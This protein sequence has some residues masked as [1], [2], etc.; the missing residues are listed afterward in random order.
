[1]T[2]IFGPQKGIPEKEEGVFL[3][4]FLFFG[5]LVDVFWA[6]FLRLLVNWSVSPSVSWVGSPSVS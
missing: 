5:C 1:M 3:F 2:A 4:F 6:G